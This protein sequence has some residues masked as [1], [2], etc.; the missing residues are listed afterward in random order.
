VLPRRHSTE[1]SRLGHSAVCGSYTE[2]SCRETSPHTIPALVHCRSTDCQFSSP[3][4]REEATEYG[5]RKMADFIETRVK[6]LATKSRKARR[7]YSL[8]ASARGSYD[9]VT[10]LLGLG[11]LRS[12]RRHPLI[13]VLGPLPI[14][15]TL[16]GSTFARSLPQ[17]R[18]ASALERHPLPPDLNYSFDP[19]ISY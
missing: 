19:Y 11:L 3:Q 9:H 2:L 13:T 6:E 17:M 7:C 8:R 1:S 15:I 12:L 16:T 5:E 14:L 10:D 18:S 4:K